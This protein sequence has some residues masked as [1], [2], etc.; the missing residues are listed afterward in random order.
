MAQ[1]SRKVLR[2]GVQN[3]RAPG[4]R[5]DGTPIIDFQYG[6]CFVHSLTPRIFEVAPR[7]LENL[8]IPLLSMEDQTSRL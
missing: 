6:I 3:S 8:C 1:I 7:F 5:D 2:K 4:Y